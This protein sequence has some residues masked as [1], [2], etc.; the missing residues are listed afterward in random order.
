[1][2]KVKVPEGMAKNPIVP[3]NNECDFFKW[4]PDE[5]RNEAIRRWF[6]WMCERMFPGEE[7]VPEELSEILV[8]YNAGVQQDLWRAYR[9]G[10]AAGR[11]Q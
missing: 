8:C 5:S 6:K 11:K 1:M 3:T 4:E 7:E 2:V 10:Q 9:L